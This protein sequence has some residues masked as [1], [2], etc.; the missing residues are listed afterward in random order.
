[1]DLDVY[2]CVSCGRFSADRM[3]GSPA[4]IEESLCGV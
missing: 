2:V 1:M 4:R 3:V